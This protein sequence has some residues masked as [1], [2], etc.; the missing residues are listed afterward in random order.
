[1]PQLNASPCLPG[2]YLS[3]QADSSLRYMSVLQMP[4]SSQPLSACPWATLIHW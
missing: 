3:R 4:D 1:M 2:S